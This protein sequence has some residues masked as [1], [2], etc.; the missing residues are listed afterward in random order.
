MFGEISVLGWLGGAIVFA[1]G[2]GAGYF[3]ARQIKDKRTLELEQQLEATQNKL[4]DYQEDVHRHFLKT[5][6]LFNKLTDDYREV[7]EHLASGAQT[8][9]NEKTR[10]SALDLPE[11]KILAAGTTDEEGSLNAEPNTEKANA[12]VA[13]TSDSATESEA[14]TTLGAEGMVNTEGL[15][16]GEKPQE[17]E[18]IRATQA[19]HSTDAMSEGQHAAEA[20]IIE[21]TAEALAGGPSANTYAEETSA[22]PAK[23]KKTDTPAISAEELATLDAKAAEKRKQHEEEDAHLGAESTPGVE[24]AHHKTHPSIH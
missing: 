23:G 18:N 19:S 4:N 2:G 17:A 21:P 5:S 11:K 15:H 13:T 10:I 22:G 6:L 3:I 24:P 20:G 12:A 16:E 1:I 9:C 8:L 14:N 7:Y